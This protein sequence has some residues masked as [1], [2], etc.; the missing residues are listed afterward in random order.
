MLVSSATM[1]KLTGYEIFEQIYA[2]SRTIVYRGRRILD[3]QPV[4]IKLLQSEY[5]SVKELVLFRNQ[6]TIAKNLAHPGIIKTY[7]LENYRNGYALVMEDFGG[8]SLQQFMARWKKGD[9]DGLREFFLIAIQ[10]ASSLDGLYRHQVIHKDIKPANILFN[11]TTGEVKLIDFSIASLL[12]QESQ[13]L[14][15]INVLEGT[16]A[17]LSPEQTGRMNR[18]IDYRTDFYS[19]GVTFYQLLTGQLPFNSDD[20]IELVYC[21]L[22]KQPPQVHTINPVIP[23]VLSDIVSK[24]MAKNAED[25]Y[26]SALGL[27]HDLEI[28][29]S[30]WQETGNIVSFDL[31]Q[32]DMSDRFIIPEKL[33]GREEQVKTLLEAFERVAARGV[34]KQG[35]SELVLIAGF[36]GVGKTALV[37]EIHKPIVRARGYFI[38]GKFDQFQSEI[39]F[40]GF[41]QAFQDLIGQLLTESTEQVEEWRAK[42]Q[43]AMGENGQVITDLI[44]ELELLIGKQPPLIELEPNAAQNRFNLMF[45]KFIRVFP[46][47]NHPIV[48]FLDDLQSCDSASLKFIQSLMSDTEI[49]HLLLIGAYRDNEVETRHGASLHPLMLTL[50]EI[51]KTGATVNTITLAPLSLN[52]LNCLI[53]D[54]LNTTE[55]TAIPLTQFVFGLTKGNPFFS[56]QLLKTLHEDGLITFN[57]TPLCPPLS[58]GDERGVGW[59]WDISQVRSLSLTSDVVEFMSAQLKKL[60]V[61]TQAAMKIAACIGSSFELETVAIV[62]GKSPVE[63]ADDLCFAL[64]SGLILQ[65]REA[66]KVYHSKESEFTIQNSQNE[67]NSDS[68]NPTPVETFHGTSLQILTPDSSCYYKF[69]HDRV[70][71]A[72]YNLIP[73]DQKKFIHLKIGQL[74]LKHDRKDVDSTEEKIFEI[75]NQLNLALELI[76]YQ[77]ERD[78]LAQLNLIAGGKAKAATAYTVA[79]K[80]LTTGIQLLPS[81]SW[82]T[83]YELTLALYESAAE[84]AYLSGDFEQTEQLVQVVLAKAKTLLEKVKV[85]EVKI[86][87][88]GGQGKVIEAINIALTFLKHLGVEFPEHPNQLDV[89]RELE[90]TSVTL[91]DRRIEEL[92]NLPLMTKAQPLAVMRILSNAS[93][94]AY[95]VIP[96]LYTLI[97]LKQI[98]LS[99][100]HGNTSLSAFAYV[101]YGL[102][103][104]VVV[105]D[106]ESGYKFGKLALNLVCKINAKEVKAKIMMVLNTGIRPWKEHTKEILKPLLESNFTAIVTGDLQFSAFS[107]LSYSYCSYFIGRELSALE[108]EMA[109]YSNVIK[110]IKQERAFYWNEIYR[111]TVLNLLGYFENTSLLI[112]EKRNENKILPLHIETNDKTGLLHLYL[113]KMYLFYLFE[114]FSQ[115]VENGILAEKYLDSGIGQLVFPL[116]HFYNSLAQLAVYSEI[117]EAEQKQVLEKVRANQDKMHHWAHHAPMNFLHKFYLVEAERHRVLGEN[118]EA[119]DKYDRAIALAKENEYI[120]EEALAYEL[121]AKFYLEWGKEII[122]QTYMTNAYYAYERWGALAKLNDL[123]QRYPQLLA[124]IR[125]RENISLNVRSEIIT[126]TATSISTSSTDTNSISCSSISEALDLATFIKASLALSGEIQLDKLLSTV[127]E[128]VIENAGAHNGALILYKSENLVIEAQATYNNQKQ[129]LEISCLQSIPIHESQ[130]LPITLVNYVARTSQILVINDVTTETSFATDQY[131]KSHQPKSVLCTPIR[132]QGKVIGILYLENNLT[133]GAFTHDREQVLKLLI[134]QAAISLENAILYSNLAVANEQLEN[135][136]CELEQKVAQRTQELNQKNQDLAQTLQELKRTQAQLIQTE[137]MSSLGQMVAGIAHEINN[138]I[139]FIRGNLV[140]VNQYVQDL[141]DLIGVYQQE[142]PSNVK[143]EETIEQIDLDFLVEDLPK[144]LNSMIVGS[145]RIRNIVLGLR[146]FSRLDEADM[147]PVDIH[148]GIDNTLMILQHRLQDKSGQTEIQVI[149][150]YGQLPQVTCYASQ[151]NQALMNILTNAIDAIKESFVKSQKSKVENQG[152]ITKDK[153]LL[154][155]PQIRICTELGD[156]HTVRIRIAD[157]G[158]GMTEEVQQKIFDPFF[159]TKPVGSGTGLGLS[160]SYQIV[161][162]KHQGRLTC[163][164]TPREGTEFVIEIPLQQL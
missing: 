44:P 149:K 106:I 54:T 50:N 152:L 60:P 111:V 91:A 66:C 160:I 104:C 155:N 68:P 105:G 96:E 88:Y 103:L 85:Y 139:N 87:A 18:L 29:F 110:E 74:L 99:L 72:A 43:A 101:T 9:T 86:Q 130:D 121:T 56:S 162:E 136:N 19:L 164:S 89:Q 161:V 118:L 93:P 135:Y 95:Q 113:N 46:S 146:N 158:I 154:T 125:R 4:V 80:Y 115:A 20:P 49:Q 138:P 108:R 45:H 36:S 137:K 79:V 141:L 147:K 13:A 112:C 6:Y 148:E 61:Q 117:E 132:N 94:L 122:A 31:G 107:L 55:D 28:C 75:V 144:L 24:L 81:D 10:I 163:S 47:E 92:I 71:Q 64:Q 12:K 53:A 38:K 67:I 35:G 123:E 2:G 134:T 140:H 39:P 57:P 114:K 159:T 153:E 26:Q 76:T 129:V 62:H 16:L 22:A 126:D 151:L 8:I 100:E 15:S 34:G 42:I 23:P 127:M 145:D 78:E 52:N 11:S 69:L 51:R 40:L 150:N 27:K 128:V 142:F 116:F 70:Q 33:Y 14:R 63:T 109:I 48:I 3:Q 90:K 58:R 98:N 73:E 25:R 124:S 133:T 102:I 77:R 30:Q 83:N 41:V 37:N 156:N 82:E 120:N 119:M 32:R 1:V 7:S 65:V 97:A 157:N 59:Q 84:V 21:H 131:I 5:P 143:V 17:Y